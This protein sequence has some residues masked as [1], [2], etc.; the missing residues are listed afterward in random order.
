[1]E[2]KRGNFYIPLFNGS[3]YSNCKL[4]M[5]KFLQF[6]KCENVVLRARINTDD[7]KWD[8]RDIQATNY[9]Y[10]PITNKQHT[11]VNSIQL[12]DNFINYPIL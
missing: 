1:M 11:S 4:R 3:D 7:Y 6:K 9:I 2:A 10:S 8:E 5:F 12:L